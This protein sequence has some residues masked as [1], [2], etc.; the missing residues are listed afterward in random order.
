MRRGTGGAFGRNGG[1]IREGDRRELSPALRDKRQ[2]VREL[3]D[4]YEFQLPSDAQTYQ[5]ATEWIDGERVCCPF[6]DISLRV[7]PD[8]GPLWMRLTGRP[9][10]KAFIQADAADWIKQ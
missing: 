8:G 6:F 9:G 5:Q 3:A 2:A 4:G 7:M 1:L 10:T